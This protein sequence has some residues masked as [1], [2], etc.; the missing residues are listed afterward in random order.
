[1]I[2]DLGI[3]FPIKRNRIRVGNP[4]YKINIK[5]KLIKNKAILLV[6]KNKRANNKKIKIKNSDFN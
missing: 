2:I 3:N 6:T 1:M 5:R 4:I